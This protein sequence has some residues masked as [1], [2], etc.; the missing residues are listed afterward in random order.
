M[1]KLEPACIARKFVSPA[2]HWKAEDI[3]PSLRLS[4]PSVPFSVAAA[5]KLCA[6]PILYS[7]RTDGRGGSRARDVALNFAI[8]NSVK[9]SLFPPQNGG[10]VELGRD[11]LFMAEDD[12][13]IPSWHHHPGISPPSS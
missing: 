5:H 13:K 10:G 12:D 6:R 3:R 8:L 1:A 11:L 2:V 7:G 4:L 9:L